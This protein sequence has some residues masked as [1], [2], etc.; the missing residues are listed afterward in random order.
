L[1][2]GAFLKSSLFNITNSFCVVN[3]FFLLFKKTVSVGAAVR[4]PHRLTHRKRSC[5]MFRMKLSYRL[6]ASALN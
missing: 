1:A 4:R 2:I 5:P 6:M 3:S